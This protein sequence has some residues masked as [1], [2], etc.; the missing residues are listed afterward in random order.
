M[1]Y[2]CFF[3]F[4]VQWIFLLYNTQTMQIKSNIHNIIGMFALKNLTYT[5]A[6]FD[7][8]SSVP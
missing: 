4:I 5:L 8:G 3:C 2:A 6:G 1:C 7:P